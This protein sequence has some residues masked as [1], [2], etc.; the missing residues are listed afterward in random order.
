[1]NSCTLPFLFCFCQ[2]CDPRITA[3]FWQTWKEFEVRHGN[4]DTMR[5]MLRIKRSVQATYNT[6][7]NMMAAQF[8]NTNNDSAADGA[9]NGVNGGLDAMRLLEEKARQAAA[10]EPKQ[11]PAE[12]AAMDITFVRG[13]TQGGAKNNNSVVNPDEIDIGDSDEDE[14]DEDEENAG[15]EQATDA[16]AATKTDDEGLIMKKLR[17]EQKAIPAK[18]F[19][20]LK[21]NNHPESDEE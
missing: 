10:A 1:M 2:V 13:E 8:L 20:S 15:I 14:D 11:K 6:Q 7:V 17:F 12:K 9:G 5:E 4:E 3:D 16:S 19:G 18:V 21:T